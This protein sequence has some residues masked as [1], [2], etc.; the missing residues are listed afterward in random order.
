M[1]PDQILPL[2]VQSAIPDAPMGGI[3]EWLLAY[4]TVVLVHAYPTFLGNIRQN[5]VISWHWTMCFS[6][7]LVCFA[8]FTL[9]DFVFI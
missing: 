2:K 4:S 8:F 3:L 9:I 1:F 5:S 7:V 6:F